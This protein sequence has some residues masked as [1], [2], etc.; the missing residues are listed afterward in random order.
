M[1]IPIPIKAKYLVI[2]YGLIEFLPVFQIYQVIMWLILPSGWYAIWIFPDSFL[3]KE[4]SWKWLLFGIRD[5]PIS[6]EV[7]W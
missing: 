7:P 3:E 5:Y 6:S 1:F 2:G 4:R